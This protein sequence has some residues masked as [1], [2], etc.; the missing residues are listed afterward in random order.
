MVA[1]NL[2]ASLGLC[3]D[4]HESSL[5]GKK[6][7]KKHL[8]GNNRQARKYLESAKGS[9]VREIYSSTKEFKI[10]DLEAT[11]KYKRTKGRYNSAKGYAKCRN[12]HWSIPKKEYLDLISKPCYYC[13]LPNGVQVGVGLDRIDNSK[14]YSLENCVSCCAMCNIIRGDKFSVKEMQQ[15]GE[16]IRIIKQ[17]R[18]LFIDHQTDLITRRRNRNEA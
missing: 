11:K 18:I 5:P 3:Y 16:V 15:I 17:N 9:L 13:N 6:R 1:R 10:K 7:C 2:R 12:K 14:G 8:D 4:C